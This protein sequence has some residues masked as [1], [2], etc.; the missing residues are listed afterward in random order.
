M[1]KIVIIGAG[2]FQV[3]LIKK[4]KDMGYETHVFAW[5]EGA[6][7][8]E[9]SDYFY[10]I[11][12][13][14]KEEILEICR[15]IRPSSIVSIGSDL[16][17]ITV[18]YLLRALGMPANPVGVDFAATNKYMMRQ[19]FAEN[20]ISVPRYT[21]VDEKKDLTRI[22]GFTFPIIVKPT[23]RS[24]SRGIRKVNTKEELG[25]AID[26]AIEES[27]EKRAIVEEYIKGQEYSCE[28]ISFEGQHYILAF[29]KKFTTGAPDFIETAHQQ[30]SDIEENLKIK[31]SKE[32]IKGLDS[33]Q[34]QYGA[35]HCEFKIDEFGEVKIIEIGAR[36]GGDCIGSHLV[37]ESEGYDYLKMVIDVAEGKKPEIIRTH[38]PRYA[39]IKFIFEEEDYKTLLRIQT[40]KP[41]LICEISKIEKIGSRKIID[42]SSR[43]GF[44]ILTAD[45]KEE[46]QKFISIL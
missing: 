19:S 32:I 27:F 43:F 18:N 26:A 9:I 40:E 35:S 5:R 17:V 7:G 41:E 3:P 45:T 14:D 28:T 16:A 20:C 13:V 33:L 4:A 8:A 31:A 30:P 44:Y 29:T 24:G 21:V 39:F 15:K 22:E 42:S 37:E 34:I 10:P 11:S 2:E 36:M 46:L 25:S 23:D 12:I 1:K 38:E 6:V